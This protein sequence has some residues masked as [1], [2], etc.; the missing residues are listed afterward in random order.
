MV[1]DVTEEVLRELWFASSVTG[2][3][4]GLLW[5]WS[6]GGGC[7]TGSGLEL[8]ASGSARLWL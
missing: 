7:T 5:S 3:G 4:D 6:S 8:V 1:R 2:G